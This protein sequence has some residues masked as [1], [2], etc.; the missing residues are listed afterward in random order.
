MFMID[1]NIATWLICQNIQNF[2]KNSN[3]IVMW[4]DI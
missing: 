3:I 1:V 2:K 4:N